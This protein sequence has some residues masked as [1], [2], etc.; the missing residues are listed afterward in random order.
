[1]KFTP[2]DKVCCLLAA[3]V[4][5]VF[6]LNPLIYNSGY[7]IIK[8]DRKT[9]INLKYNTYTLHI[10]YISYI[11]SPVSNPL[12]TVVFGYGGDDISYS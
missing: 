1:M 12:L 6:F 4:E 11:L 9:L 5:Q 8:D 10:Q 7:V 2:R 3:G